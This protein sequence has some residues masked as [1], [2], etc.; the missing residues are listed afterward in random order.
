MASHVALI[1]SRHLARQVRQWLVEMARH[2]R[3]RLL[4]SIMRAVLPRILTAGQWSHTLRLPALV[5]AAL[6]A[7]ALWR[8][9]R[10][11]GALIAP[12]LHPVVASE[13]TITVSLLEPLPLVA[14][15]FEESFN[16]H[17]E[18]VP[19]ASEP[20]DVDTAGSVLAA[21]TVPVAPVVAT[22]FGRRELAPRRAEGLSWRMVPN[23]HRLV[24]EGE[25]KHLVT[26][27]EVLRN[28]LEA[29]GGFH[30]YSQSLETTES[31]QKPSAALLT[32]LFEHVIG[33]CT[34]SGV[35]CILVQQG[36][37]LSMGGKKVVQF[38]LFCDGLDSK[39]TVCWDWNV[40][41]KT[42]TSDRIYELPFEF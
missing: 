17:S 13:P 10:P 14:S 39:A 15:T 8:R 22:P 4:G 33:E 11:R 35:D 7:M 23:V 25:K 16:R 5:A 27:L 37:M 12:P 1:Q 28:E 40:E 21:C 29:Y 20:V 19:P 2:G 38:E 41:L 32:K 34:Q 6:A 9:A 24:R 3:W 42:Q 31:P 26:C 18:A 30:H 36:L